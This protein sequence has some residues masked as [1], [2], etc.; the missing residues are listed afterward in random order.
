[1]TGGDWRASVLQVFLIVLGVIIY[2]P[3]LKIS[4]RVLIKQAELEQD[5]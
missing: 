4:E 5:L 1:A 3:F 2:L